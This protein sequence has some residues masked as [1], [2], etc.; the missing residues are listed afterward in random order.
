MSELGRT[1]ERLH[2]E[3][4]R[5]HA[6]VFSATLAQLHGFEPMLTN[7]ER[8]RFDRVRVPQQ[9]RLHALGR[10]LVR[11]FLDLPCT[12]F[13]TAPAGKIRV[14]GATHFN[15]SHTA[16]TIA[17]AV[18]PSRAVGVDIE[19]RARAVQDAALI[20]RVC[21][22]NEIRWIARHAPE[23][24]T[25]AFLRCWVRKEALLKARGTGLVDDLHTIDTRADTH[26]ADA[27]ATGVPQLRLW[28]FPQSDG[29]LP[30]ALATASDVAHVHFLSP[31]TPPSRSATRSLADEPCDAPCV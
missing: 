20:A 27:H 23:Q 18:H 11:Y 22:P 13:T 26:D 9:R 19:D 28:D 4:T 30:G 1:K 21:H 7:A 2:A 25:L 5:G 6:I 10:G 17:V 3:M 8:A 12:E 15:I 24:R 29:A 31:D 16:D 14:P